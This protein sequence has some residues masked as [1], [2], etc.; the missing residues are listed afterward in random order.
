MKMNCELLGNG[1]KFIF[2][3]SVFIILIDAPIHESEPGQLTLSSLIENN[4]YYYLSIGAF[5]GGDVEGE[6]A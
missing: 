1:Q 2:H 4:Y 3:H 6:Q 5:G